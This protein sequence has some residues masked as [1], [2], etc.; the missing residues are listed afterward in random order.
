MLGIIF[1]KVMYLDLFQSGMLISLSPGAK[2]PEIPTVSACSSSFAEPV[3]IVTH[4]M[5]N[6]CST[7]ESAGS[8]FKPVSLKCTFYY[9]MKS[10]KGW[11]VPASEPALYRLKET[12][13]CLVSS[14]CF[15]YTFFQIN[16]NWNWIIE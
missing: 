7:T 8:I 2:R 11:I 9:M 6:Y 3:K 13:F 5:S 1:E 15:S 16:W 10:W 14:T 4:V 12:N